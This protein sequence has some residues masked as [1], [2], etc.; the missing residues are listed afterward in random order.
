MVLDKLGNSL[1]DTMKKIARAKRIDKNLVEEVT[2]DIQRALLQ[3]DVNVR[4]VMQLSDQIKE[5]SLKERPPK[6]ANPREQVIRIVYE[7]LINIVGKNIEVPLTSQTILMAGLQG[8]GKTLSTAKLAAYFQRKGLKPAVICADTYRP[9][10]YDQLQQLCEAANIPFYGEKDCKDAVAIVKRG[11]KEIGKHEVKVIDTAGRHS[12]EDDL[13]K[14]M[15]KI[16]KVAK[17]DHNFLVLDAAI[18]QLASEQARAFHDAIG[19]TGVIITKLDGTAK[20]GGALSAVSM[21]DSP[22]AFIGTGETI[23]DLE[24]FEPDSFISRLLGMGDIKALVERAEEALEPDEIDVKALLRGKFTLKDMYSQLEAVNK[25]GP[26][27]QVMSMI[28]TSGLGL[29]IS[30]ETYQVTGDKLNTYKVVM[31]SMTE[32]EMIEPRI[33]GSSRVKRISR[34]S[35]TTPEDVRELLKYHKM[36]QKAMKAMRGGRFPMKKMMQKFNM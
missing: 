1:R 26:L 33:I 9:G 25:L 35:G 20:G 19:I 30:D 10:A 32:E 13:I 23:S 21:T 4:L 12:L 14:E 6:G 34:G 22:I 18:G 27:K 15:E 29:E 16:H 3:A 2:R 31:D 8:S 11:L 7:E 24:S 17:A 36:M 28:P 5:R